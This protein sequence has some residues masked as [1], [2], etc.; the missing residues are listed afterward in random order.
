MESLWSLLPIGNEHV[1]ACNIEGIIDFIE[2]FRKIGVN[3]RAVDRT[4]SFFA[5]L[6]FENQNF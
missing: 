2:K 1:N 3:T 6:K 5:E 4:R